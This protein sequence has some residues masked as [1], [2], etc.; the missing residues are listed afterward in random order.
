[1]VS[2]GEIKRA[3]EKFKIPD[4]TQVWIELPKNLGTKNGIPVQPE[5]IPESIWEPE[6]KIVPAG[7]LAIGTFGD[8]NYPRLVI[9]YSY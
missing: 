2:V 4:D 9:Y 7:T 6:F 3:I 8:V 5:I 1:M